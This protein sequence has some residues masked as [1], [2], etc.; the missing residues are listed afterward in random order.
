MGF[1]NYPFGF[2]DGLTV[3]GVPILNS[4]SGN[5]FWVDSN[6]GSD[7][8]N[9]N[10]KSPERPFKTWDYAIGLCRDNKGDKIM[11]MPNHTETVTGASGLTLDKIGVDSIGLGHGADRANL[12]FTTAITA[13]M[14]MSAASNTIQNVLM[15]SGFDAL[16]APVN[17]QAAD[18]ALINCETRDTTGSYQTVDFILTNASADRL[19]MRGW[20]HRG[21]KSNAGATSAIKIVGGDDIEISDIDLDGTFSTAAIHNAIT[22]SVDIRISHGRIRNRASST[23]CITMN[24]N[25]ATGWIGRDLDLRTNGGNRGT[26]LANI[27]SMQIMHRVETVTANGKQSNL[28]DVGMSIKN[29]L[30]GNG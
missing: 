17:I 23:A 4:Y 26:A 29:I 2:L 13:T 16:T 14:I 24:S 9:N 8:G 21:D 30:G 27:G 7:V 25:S 6:A 19:V 3:R 28:S 10:G 18:I 1:T 22:D 11:L 20:K 5:I 12:N 15:T